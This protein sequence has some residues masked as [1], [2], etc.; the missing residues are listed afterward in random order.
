MRESSSYAPLRHREP[1]GLELRHGEHSEWTSEGGPIAVLRQ[2]GS[3]GV[4]RYG[5]RRATARLRELSPKSGGTAIFRPEQH[6][7]ARSFFIFTAKK[8]TPMA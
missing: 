1:Q 2:V 6:F 8:N 7:A 4:P 5:R 3:D